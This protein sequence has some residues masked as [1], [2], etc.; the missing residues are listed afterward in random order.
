MT[1][2]ALKRRVGRE[3]QAQ[4]EPATQQPDVVARVALDHHE[5]DG[6]EVFDASGV[7]GNHDAAV[8]DMHELLVCSLREHPIPPYVVNRVSTETRD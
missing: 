4:Q 2:Q 7:E 5:I 1:L 8:P 3:P 6:T